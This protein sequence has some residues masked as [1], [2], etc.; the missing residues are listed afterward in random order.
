MAL[1][2]SPTFPAEG[3]SSPGRKGTPAYVLMFSFAVHIHHILREVS[4]TILGES[5]PMMMAFALA[6][7]QF[8]QLLPAAAYDS[9]APRTALAHSNMASQSLSATMTLRPTQEL[10]RRQ[11]QTVFAYV[12]PDNTVGYVDGRIGDFLSFSRVFHKLNPLRGNCSLL[13]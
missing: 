6:L 1:Y 3:R 7:L 5:A 4:G 9:L 2:K 8:C 13:R 11:S 10:L 12:A